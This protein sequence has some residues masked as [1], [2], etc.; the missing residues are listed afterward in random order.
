MRSYS[1][2]LGNIQAW[3]IYI[4]IFFIVTPGA[5]VCVCVLGERGGAVTAEKR[6]EG[7]EGGEEGGG[8]GGLDQSGALGGSGQQPGPLQCP[9]PPAPPMTNILRKVKMYALSPMFP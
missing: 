3:Q 4:Y 1:R 5:Q 6:E 9:P 8:E 7:G 2:L